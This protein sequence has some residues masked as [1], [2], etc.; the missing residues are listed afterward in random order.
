M[1]IIIAIGW[2]KNAFVA[3][4]VALFYISLVNIAKSQ[5]PLCPEFNANLNHICL[6]L[7]SS[8]TKRL[9]HA[10]NF[11]EPANWI[12]RQMKCEW[13]QPFSKNTCD[14]WYDSYMIAYKQRMKSN[15]SDLAMQK[16]TSW[17]S[18]NL[19]YLL[20]FRMAHFL[21]SFKEL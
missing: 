21:L 3:Y 20:Q 16:Y 19:S 14:P 7:N 17:K 11:K 8:K 13:C 9:L 10:E 2:K 15:E 18:H 6:S 1:R 4:R 5:I 12:L